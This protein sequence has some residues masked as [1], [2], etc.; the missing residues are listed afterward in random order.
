MAE[1]R[2]NALLSQWVITAGHRQRRT[3]LPARS[4]C[5]L[6]PSRRGRPTELPDLPFEIAVFENRFPSLQRRPPRPGTAPTP[7]CPVARSRGACE[8]IVYSPRHDLS[9]GKAPPRLA[10][11]LV[12]VWLDRHRELARRRGIDYVFIFENRGRAIGVTL[13][14]PHGQ[15]YAFPYVPPVIERE[16]ASFR[17]FRK[18]TG[19][20]LGCAACSEESRARRRV[21]F[22]SRGFVAFVPFA[23]RWPY[24]VHLYPRRHA[25][26]LADL[27]AGERGGLGR[28]IRTVQRTYDRLFGFPLPFTMVLHQRPTDGRRYEGYHFHVEFYSP[29]RAATRLKY[30]AGCESGAGSFINDS[31][32][33]E[34]ARELR[35]ALRRARRNP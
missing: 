29:Q 28:A 5:P 20:C 3:H 13:T 10:E 19:R 33:E 17:D 23:A 12:E 31:R 25:R 1:L 2:W 4:A 21:L 24:E 27:D 14:H 26:D 32:P 15:I 16:L 8:V 11:R 7:I 30:L 6:C 18:T 34:K 22:Q 9:L 35:R